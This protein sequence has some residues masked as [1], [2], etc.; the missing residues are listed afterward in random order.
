MLATG[1]AQR[2]P[3][4][5]VAHG[6]FTA[7]RR[8]AEKDKE[9]PEVI[10]TFAGELMRQICATRCLTKICSSPRFSV[11]AVNHAFP[12]IGRRHR[13]K[14]ALERLPGFMTVPQP[15]GENRGFLGHRELRY[16]GCSLGKSVSDPFS[17]PLLPGKG[18][19]RHL[20]TLTGPSTMEPTAAAT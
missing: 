14:S 7:E 20:T 8:G 19:Y 17:G 6:L 9:C 2:N 13:R 18:T 12:G 1:V 11:S 4:L 16:R 10:S 5:A 15:P 3:W